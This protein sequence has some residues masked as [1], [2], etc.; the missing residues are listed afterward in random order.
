MSELPEALKSVI[1]NEDAWKAQEQLMALARG[2]K[3]DGI[4][5][6]DIT[7]AIADVALRLTEEERYS[8]GGMDRSRRLLNDLAYMFFKKSQY[9]EEREEAILRNMD[10]GG[11]GNRYSC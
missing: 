9:L 2:L 6:R 11:K 4:S 7:R 8:K 3:E 1:Y 5:S 10:V